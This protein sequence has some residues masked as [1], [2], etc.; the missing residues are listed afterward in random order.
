M[1]AN[2][3]SGWATQI[4]DDKAIIDNI[5]FADEF[6]YGDVVRFKRNVLGRQM[7]Y[8]V[9]ERKYPFKTAYNYAEPYPETFDRLYEVWKDHDIILEGI[10]EGLCV[11]AHKI[12]DEPLTIALAAGISIVPH[13]TQPKLTKPT[14]LS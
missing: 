1:F 14:E 11:V 9:I 6:N 12:G 2:D 3:E 7:A 4:D 5:P 10:V 13:G 8:A